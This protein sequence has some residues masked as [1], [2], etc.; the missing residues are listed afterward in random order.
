L[1]EE[2]E[3]DLKEEF[4]Y[5]LQ[6]NGLRKARLDYIRSVLGFIKPFTL[7]RKKNLHHHNSFFHMNMFRHYFVVGLR[8]LRKNAGYS[9]INIS[10]LAIGLTAFIMIFLWV[11][12]ELSYDRFNE[13]ADRI[14][15][16]VENQ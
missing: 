4:E 16:V 3:G 11:R 7:K 2:I 10:G 14:Y 1:L 5:Q 13:Q 9:Y 15:R 12:N 6:Q 8:S